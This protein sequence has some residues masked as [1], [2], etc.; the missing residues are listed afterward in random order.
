MSC[1]TIGTAMPAPN[2]SKLAELARPAVRP[3]YPRVAEAPS[4]VGQRDALAPERI[5]A[6]H[7]DRRI[8]VGCTGC[9]RRTHSCT[10]QSVSI[11]TVFAQPDAEH[12]HS[13][14]RVVAGM[15]GRQIPQA[16][17]MLRDAEAD[18]LAFTGFPVSQ[19][20]DLVDQPTGTAQQGE[21]APHRRRRRLSNPAACSASPAPSW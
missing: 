18:L 15:L 21:Q 13:Q 8:G 9:A 12:V 6:G 1:W 16:E 5:D 17:T 20:E 2:R 4:T 3:R 14:L 11:R 7:G 10:A 19:K